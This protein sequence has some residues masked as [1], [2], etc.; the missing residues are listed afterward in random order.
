MLCFCKKFSLRFVF[1]NGL[2]LMIFSFTRWVRC[3]FK[4]YTCGG[5]FLLF[6]GFTIIFPVT[7]VCL[8]CFR[9]HSTTHF[10]VRLAIGLSQM[11]NTGTSSDSISLILKQIDLT[12]ASSALI[13]THHISR[14]TH[15]MHLGSCLDLT[16]LMS[17]LRF[18][19]LEFRSQTETFHTFTSSVEQTEFHNMSTNSGKHK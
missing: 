13:S 10:S 16:L 14:V 12:L 6:C 19:L 8:K 15:S 2:N 17:H 5:H 4:N 7:S 11:P 1:I 9:L 3:I 18:F